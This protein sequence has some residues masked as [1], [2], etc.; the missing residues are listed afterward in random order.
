MLGK[1]RERDFSNWEPLVLFIWFQINILT[2]QVVRGKVIELLKLIHESMNCI[3]YGKY[4][5]IPTNT[6]LHLII[7]HWIKDEQ[8]WNEQGWCLIVCSGCH[9]QARKLFQRI[10][11]CPV[12]YKWYANVCAIRVSCKHRF[13]A[14]MFRSLFPSKQ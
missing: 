8:Y 13:S 6:Y 7:L 12:G 1:E 5:H 14:S 9:A 11:I 10:R 3:T 2:L 4:W